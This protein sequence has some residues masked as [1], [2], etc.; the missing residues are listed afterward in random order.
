MNFFLQGQRLENRKITGCIDSYRLHLKKLQASDE[1]SE[2]NKEKTFQFK[3]HRGDKRNPEI[4]GHFKL[5]RENGF[6]L[7]KP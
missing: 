4:M 6:Q 2:L 7:V 1:F 5:G 3:T